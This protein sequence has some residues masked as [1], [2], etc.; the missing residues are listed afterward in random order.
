VQSTDGDGLAIGA[1]VGA[2]VEVVDGD[3]ALPEQPASVTDK[4]T[5]ATMDIAC[6]EVITA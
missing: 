2:E 5:A 4:A 6:L 3:A 1:A